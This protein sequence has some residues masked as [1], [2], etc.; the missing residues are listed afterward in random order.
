LRK[1][2]RNGKRFKKENMSKKDELFQEKRK[3]SRNTKNV[4]ILE[5]YTKR[6]FK[7]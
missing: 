2:S 6:E 5:K 1:L 7:N 4:Q 3:I